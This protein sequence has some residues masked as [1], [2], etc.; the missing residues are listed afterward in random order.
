MRYVLEGSVRK[1]RQRV[2][3]TGQLIDAMTGAHLYQNFRKLQVADA[4]E[5]ARA[6]RA[7][8]LSP[9]LHDLRGDMKFSEVPLTA[10]RYQART[11]TV[12]G[13]QAKDAAE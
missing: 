10:A 6:K 4:I 8:P 7:E 11:Y 1:A 9:V 5:K 12:F 13:D 2:R 3:I